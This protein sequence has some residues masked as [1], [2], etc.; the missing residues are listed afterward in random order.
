M[1]AHMAR[2]KGQTGRESRRFGGLSI[3][4]LVVAVLLAVAAGLLVPG[5]S[6]RAV[7]ETTSSGTGAQSFGAWY[8]GEADAKVISASA[9]S[10]VVVPIR[11]PFQ[12][13]RRWEDD[14]GAPRGSSSHLGND[15][16]AP[17]GT[18]LVAVVSGYLDGDFMNFGGTRLSDA[19]GLP[20]FNIMLC[21]DDGND[22]FYI[23]LNNDSR[24]TD[25]TYTNDGAGGPALAYAPGLHDGSRVEAGQLLGWVGDSGW[26]NGIPHLHFE[27]HV[28]GWASDGAHVINPYA[29]LRAAYDALVASGGGTTATTAKPT[30]T[31]KPSTTTTTLP[32]TTTTTRAPGGQLDPGAPRFTD[33]KIADWFYNDLG[34]LCTAGV[35]RGSSDGLFRPYADITRAQF[36]AFLA[37]TFLPE[38]VN[39]QSAASSPRAFAD[40]SPAYWGYPEI[41]AAAAAGLVKGTAVGRFS[42]DVLITRAQMAAMICRALGAVSADLLQEAPAKTASF[43]DVTAGSC[44]AVEE[45][46]LAAA[47]GIVG[48]YSDGTFRPEA[49]ATRAQAVAVLARALRLWRNG[50]EF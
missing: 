23:H 46:G 10:Q 11:F 31:T 15:I 35:V 17:K 19:D 5:F 20:Y 22:Y 32:P 8:A 1:V 14:F 27:I 48:G 42:P 30:T 49:N 33:V 4:R 2:A 38:K 7:S 43:K 28:G 21:G 26:S 29:S 45:V 39:A 47:L 41:Q 50:A 13:P 24:G 37:R 18:P 40:V 6:G 12:E 3:S 44:W 16:L 36:T 34:L 25:G 9:A